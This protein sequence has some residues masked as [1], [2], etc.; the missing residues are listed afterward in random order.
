MKKEITTLLVALCL[1][2]GATFAQQRSSHTAAG[3]DSKLLSRT[4]QGDYVVSRYLVKE[5]SPDN[6]EFSVK[7][8]IN[9]SRLI[10]T[11]DNNADELKGL[12][13]FVEEL[14]QD[15][16]KQIV[17]VDVTGYASPD[18]PA[19]INQKLS[20]ERAQDFRQYINKNYQMA[21]YSGATK[22]DA[23]GW[24]AT[25][26]AVSE[27]S[28]PQKSEV[29]ALV[30]SGRPA[31]EIETK[32]KAMPQSWSYMKSN[33]LPPMRCVE[34]WVK[35]NSWKVVEE[36]VHVSQKPQE[37]EVI[38]TNY[39]FIVEDDCGGLIVAS[40]APLDYGEE[41]CKEKFKDKF[42]S[43]H[44]RDKF[45]EKGRMGRERSRLKGK[46]KYRRKRR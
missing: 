2:G 20:M 38:E 3:A 21:Q 24:S 25:S 26:S 42:K 15:T 44:H 5:T 16:L 12:R 32:L 36:R 27:S 45:K 41:E 43:N 23:L 29:L 19:D 14:R 1:A 4:T 28:M 22:A 8:K 40:N 9:L 13:S 31:S 39:I 46:D 6:N 33:I 7:Y 37:V 35:Y 10:S 34:M 30:N 18:G 11:Y 17:S